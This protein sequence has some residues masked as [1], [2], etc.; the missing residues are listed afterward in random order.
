MARVIQN[1]LL[2]IF[3]VFSCMLPACQAVIH[4]KGTILDPA[5]VAKIQV[6]QTTSV[7]V[8]ESLGT[9]TFIN[10]FL[11]N[12]WAYV[13]DRPFKNLQRTFAR[14]ANRVEITFDNHGIVQ[15]IQHNFGTALLNPE[16]LPSAKNDQSW[17]RWLWGGEYMRP[18]TE[19]HPA[20]KASTT[21]TSSEP[22]ET[23]DPGWRF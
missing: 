5:S 11:K 14:A 20:P 6:G 16:T 13:Q 8:R 10:P 18:A 23:S 12:R 3:F 19:R 2:A 22:E 21:H 1:P 17:L 7:Q 15:E 9:P 4:E